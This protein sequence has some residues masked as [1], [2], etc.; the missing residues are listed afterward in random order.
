MFMGYPY[1]K[2]GWRLFDL[3]K[4]EFWVSRDVVFYEDKF[5]CKDLKR[6]EVTAT[7]APILWESITGADMYEEDDPK[8]TNTQ[9]NETLGRE[10]SPAQPARPTIPIL[11]TTAQP[12]M[13][14]GSSSTSQPAIGT[15]EPAVATILEPE[16]GRGQRR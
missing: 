10:V 12:A 13:E 9:L 1:D 11:P 16:L 6:D 2:K 14:S 4:Q 3:E 8:N 5:P 15:S 7:A